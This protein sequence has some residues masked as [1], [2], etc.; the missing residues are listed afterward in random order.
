MSKFKKQHQENDRWNHKYERLDLKKLLTI[1]RENRRK[2][3]NNQQLYYDPQQDESDIKEYYR[4]AQDF[5]LTGLALFYKFQT[6]V[7]R[8]HKNQL[9]YFL[10]K[11]LYLYTWV[12]LY[13]DGSAK[14]IYSS[15]KKD[16]ESLIIEDNDTLRK[17]YDEFR[18][19]SR[20]IQVNGF[21]SIKE[22]KVFEDHFKMN[23]EHI[24]PQS[25]FDGAEPMKGD[26][27]HLFVCDPD[28]N[29]S[30]SNYPFVDF[31]FYN[32]ESE[33]EPIQNNC[34]VS[35]SFQ[36]EPEHGKGASARAMLYFFLR[37]PKMVKNE[38]KMKVN[39][40][41]LVRWNEEF[42][43]TL[44]EKHRNQAIYY[45]QGNRNPFIDFPELA[46]KIEFPW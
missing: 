36:F 44:Y 39:I 17:K 2:I 38:F 10:S 26:L 20:T 34:G 37:Y 16:P 33:D 15:E 28:C 5:D 8:T 29:I 11:D 24:V 6:L 19:R 30:R 9:P 31:D 21:D 46:E 3:K 43:P 18:R 42:P 14:S 27:H 22:L 1:L 40:P 12:D 35:T 25:W 45:I 32:P 4:S 23:T 41:L 7:F 13:P